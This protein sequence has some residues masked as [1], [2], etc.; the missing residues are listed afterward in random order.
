M[1]HN[2]SKRF[3]RPLRVELAP[4]RLLLLACLALHLAAAVACLWT[5]APGVLLVVL[6]LHLCYVYCIHIGMCLP[7]AIGVVSWDAT[8]GWRIRQVRGDWL[9]AEPV[10]PVFV[11][12]R[13]VAVRF[14]CGR[15][16]Y[17]S[18]LV[19]AQR[20]AAD[21]FRRLR[22]RL[23]QSAHGDRDRAKVPGA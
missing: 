8:R 1:S 3:D 16:S 10:F 12:Q 9:C 22:V 2:S 7:T 6:A 14:R 4:S 11:S 5:P 21:D 23:I 13:L 19:V 18:L 20:C 17:R 15:L